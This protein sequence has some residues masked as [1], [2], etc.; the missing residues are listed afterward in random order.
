[1]GGQFQP[2]QQPPGQPG[3]SG[4]Q[5][6]GQP[7]QQP[8]GQQPPGQPGQQ[9]PGQGGQQPPGQPGQQGAGQ[10]TASSLTPDDLLNN[11]SLNLT[12]DQKAKI[13][14]V[15]DSIVRQIKK[16]LTPAQLKIWRDGKYGKLTVARVLAK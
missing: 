10:A 11:A 14:R 1:M 16:V 7:G 15:G 3:Q 6:P 5:P 12:A 4:Q 2:G 8:P 9:P 13:K